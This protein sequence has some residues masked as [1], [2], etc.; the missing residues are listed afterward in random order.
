[1][2]NSYLEKL[3]FLEMAKKESQ[4]STNREQI[5][6]FNMLTGCEKKRFGLISKQIYDIW[7]HINSDSL[8]NIQ[9][10]MATTVE[11]YNDKVEKIDPLILNCYYSI[12][13]HLKL[14]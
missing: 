10:R 11:E 6:I 5:A 8:P 4:N 7:T 3:V 12:L 14:L 1:M 13:I 9:K 2:N